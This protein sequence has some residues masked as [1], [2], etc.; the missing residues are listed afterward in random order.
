MKI[1]ALFTAPLS[2]LPFTRPAPGKSETSTKRNTSPT[3][4]SNSTKTVKP[5]QLKPYRGTSIA[6][7]ESACDAVKAIGRKRFLLSDGDTPMLP[8]SGCDAS[9]CKCKYMHHDDRRDD[10]HDRRLSAA[11]KTEL[12][13]DTGSENRRLKTRGRRKS[14]L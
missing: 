1:M 8:L 14:D 2:Y 9:R 4:K 6:F 11:L 5:Q 10:D 3:K 13:E 12:Y 7:E